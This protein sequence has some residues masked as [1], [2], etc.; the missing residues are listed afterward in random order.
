VNLGT[1][2]TAGTV[3]TGL[4]ITLNVEPW[5]YEP[6]QGLER[7]SGVNIL[8]GAQRLN[9]WNDWNRLQYSLARGIALPRDCFSAS[10]SRR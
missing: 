10:K 6:P 1:F 3:G 4:K 8:N 9:G 5:N 7:P 2:E